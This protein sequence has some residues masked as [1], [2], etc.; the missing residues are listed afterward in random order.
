MRSID[1]TK[2]L[3]E[4]LF[5]PTG[6]R[7]FAVRLWDGTLDSPAH[8]EVR[9]TIVLRAPGS[10]R[11]MLLPPTE[12]SIV[13]AFLYGDVDIEGDMEAAA[14]IGDIVA[15]RLRSVGAAMRVGRRAL[16]LPAI[17]GSAGSAEP[18]RRS[19]GP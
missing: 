6:S 2:Q 11:N 7:P 19:R 9:F 13:K 10:L 18:A 16:S 4:D 15:T 17:A 8:D 12:M 5:G 14:S 3:L 1:A